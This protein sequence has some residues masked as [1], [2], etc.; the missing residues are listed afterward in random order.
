MWSVPL[1]SVLQRDVPGTAPIA[2]LEPQYSP[3]VT[4]LQ[5]LGWKA[6]RAA[7]KAGLAE[8]HRHRARPSPHSGAVV[9]VP[10]SPFSSHDHLTHF[11]ML[12]PDAW[13]NLAMTP[14]ELAI[15]PH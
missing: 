15:V 11:R 14:R 9:V 13:H 6:Q 8:E 10:D 2:L 3:D 7:C 12:A 5:K 1:R 4:Y